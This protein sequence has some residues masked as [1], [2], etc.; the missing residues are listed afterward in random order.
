MYRYQIPYHIHTST[1]YPVP[2]PNGSSI[3]LC[4]HERGLLI[5]WRGGRPIKPTTRSEEQ[6]LK[7]NGTS[8]DVL[9][10]I[11]SDDEEH[12]RNPSEAY[13]DRPE[14]EDEEEELNPNAPYLSIVQQLDLPLGTAVL[15]MSIP[16]VPASIQL[17]ELQSLPKLFRQH[18]V[19]ALACAD[20]TIRL[21]TLPLAP[22]SPSSKA[23]SEL[24]TSALLAFAGNSTW[25]E[26]VVTLNGNTTHQSLP[27]GV[28]IA[29]SP[30]LVEEKDKKPPEDN[31]DQDELPGDSTMA[32][33]SHLH[34]HHTSEDGKNQSRW[35]LIIASHSADLSGLLLIHRVPISVESLY[36]GIESADNSFLW[37]TEFLAKPAITAQLHIPPQATHG[38]C[39]CVLVAQPNGTVKIY[40]C[41]TAS[42]VDQGSWRLSLHANM[43]P[44]SDDS[45]NGRSL[46]DAKWI[47]GGKAIAVTTSDG[48]WGFWDITSGAIM[49]GGIPTPFTVSGWIGSTPIGL[50]ASKTSTVRSDTKSRLAPMTPGTRRVKQEAL[51]AGPTPRSNVST[52]GGISVFRY[53]K[54][55]NGTNGTGNDEGVAMWHVDKIIIIASLQTFWQNKV[56]GSGSLFSDG[57][58]GRIREISNIPLMGEVKRSVAIFSS[59][60][61]TSDVGY[62]S[63][64]PD[65]LI[66][67]E[68]S[69][70]I[71]ASPLSEAEASKSYN[72]KLPERVVDQQLLAQGELDVLGMSRI[73]DGL[74]NGHRLT[75][76]ETNDTLMKRKVGFAT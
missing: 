52:L 49:L 47:L 8:S 24:R 68:R 50:R 25:G 20:C 35:D 29:L 44:S 13:H 43:C 32:F 6:T 38:Q 30:R 62:T 39:P 41:N 48:E 36:L 75:N 22:P 26:Q 74:T 71:L 27:K 66:S 59:E 42:K 11:D 16:N 33:A 45:S 5:L 40:D 3:I 23:R 61:T 37:R 73:L 7:P 4:G 60:D 57:S 14:Y 56:L 65:V 18:L 34:D 12:L 31:R 46:L 53:S 17:Q 54:V 15:H 1:I 28:S 55:S 76:G 58:S 72:V 21:L 64:Q 67:G 19:V 70:V 51:F 9:M 63:S 2:A 69:L 10:I